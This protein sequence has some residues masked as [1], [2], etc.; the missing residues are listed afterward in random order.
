VGDQ[1]EA[2]GE[3]GLEWR[4]PTAGAEVLRAAGRPHPALVAR[5]D[6]QARLAEFLDASYACLVLSGDPGIGK[7]SLWEAGI[8]LAAGR[9]ATV[10]QARTSESEAALSFA[11]LSDLVEGLDDELLQSLPAPQWRALEVALC[12]VAPTTAGPDPLAIAAGFL[13]ALRAGAER[14]EVLVAIDDVQWL[15]GATGE[16]LTFAARRCAGRRIRF[17][18]SRRAGRRSPLERALEPAGVCDLAVGPMSLGA[19]SRVIGQRVPAPLPRRLLRQIHETSQGNPLLAL[20]LVRPLPST[21]MPEAGVDLPLPDL[22]DDVFGPLV[23]SLPPGQREVLLAMALSPRLSRDELS[24]VIDILDLEDAIAADLVVRERTRLRP[25]HP[26][27]AAAIRRHAGTR[28][29]QSLHLRLAEATDDPIMRARHLALATTHPSAELAAAAAHAAQLAMERGAVQDAEELA[30]HALRLTPPEAPER[31]LRAL[32]LAQSHSR[33]GDL[34]RVTELLSEWMHEIPAGRWR[35][36]AHLLLGEDADVVTEESHLE[37]ALAEAGSDPELR[38]ITLARKVIVLTVNRV[39]QIDEAEALAAEAREALAQSGE[40]AASI[41]PV[42]LHAAAWARALRGRPIADLSEA[43][44]PPA[45]GFCLYDSAVER[46]LA[47]RHVFRGEI[48]LARATF[49]RLLSLAE[50]R[51]EVRSALV[52]HVQLG[53]LELRGGNVN[54]A[55]SRLGEVDQWVALAEIRAVRN[56]L[57]AM[58]AAVTGLPGEA[59][60]LATHTLGMLAGDACPG[61]DRLEASRAAGL[62]E[63][64]RGDVGSAAGHLQSV[65]EHT[66]RHHVDDPGAFPVAGDLVE[67]LTD[68]GDVRSAREVNDRLRYLAEDQQHPWGLATAGRGDALLR[69]RAGYDDEAAGLLAGA[70]ATYGHLGLH[71]DQ[72]RTLML[73][74]RAQRRAKKRAGA[75]AALEAAFDQFTHLGAAGWA[76]Q[77]SIELARVSGRRGPDDGDELTAAER[78][79][80]TLAAGGC[81]NKEIAAQLFVSVYTVEA[82][83]SHAYAKLGVRSRSQLALRL[84]EGERAPR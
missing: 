16:V 76:T 1:E 38:A 11:G 26:L 55:R 34:H 5:E 62:A 40:A 59:V 17:L 50:E 54:A 25:A 20:E 37:Q 70:A 36:L 29:C 63:L 80:V 18:L 27:L 65:W 79:V 39:E 47:V 75:R 74:G 12:R 67:A 22:A 46:P 21:G 7:T 81:S 4:G 64:C 77:A 43:G 44:P 42:V 51:G 6:E 14:G 3:R 49:T 31:G 32:A 56:R 33:A 13:S 35:A 53:E 19:L 83:L 69:L 61:W 24:R 2:K 8:T 84:A 72:A 10:L 28:E 66:R 45:A 48:D 68:A 30:A 78:S 73:L 71:L 52:L 58:L 41:R 57:R 9:R 60:Q 23:E 15:D 82:H